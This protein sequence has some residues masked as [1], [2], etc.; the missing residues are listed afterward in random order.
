MKDY[1]DLRK[2]NDRNISKK[3]FAI[4]A[5]KFTISVLVFSLFAFGII[6][7]YN[8]VSQRYARLKYI[9][10]KGNSILPIS[11]VKGFVASSGNGGLSTYN[12]SKIYFKTISNPWIKKAKVA[13]IFPDTLYLV[14]EEKKPSA[15]IYY[16]RKVY[17][18]NNNGSVIGKYQS[19]LKLPPN[20]PKVVLN[21]NLLEN[22]QLLKAIVDIYEKLD[23]IGKINYIGVMSDSYQVVNFV[24]G[25]KVIVSSLNCPP[26]AIGRLASKWSYLNS[27]KNKLDSV[28][29]CFNNKFVLKWKKGVRK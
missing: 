11:I 12:I 25:L 6:Y 20:L 28:S 1:F 10:I 9:V 17:I 2:E 23:K 21:S 29:I 3:V 26:I 27:L 24:S 18:I 4:N 7:G 8:Q 16:R 5:I 22:K 15:F 19:Y 13:K 14:I